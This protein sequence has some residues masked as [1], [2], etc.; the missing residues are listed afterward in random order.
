TPVSADV[1]AVAPGDNVVPAGHSAPRVDAVS[2]R[3]GA[4]PE[5]VAPNNDVAPADEIASSKGAG[6][7]PASAA[8]SPSQ[9]A[10]ELATAPASASAGASGGASASASAGA[11]ADASTGAPAT[12]GAL[13][14]TEVPPWEDVPMDDGDFILDTADVDDEFETLGADPAAEAALAQLA[15]RS[16]NG[17]G[18]KLA[19]ITAADW[20]TLVQ[21]LPLTGAAEQLARQTEWLGV[22]G[23]RVRLRVGIQTLAEISARSRFCTVLSEHFGTVI[24]VDFEVG[25]TGEGTAHAIEQAHLEKLQEQAEQAVQNDPLINALIREFDGQVV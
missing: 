20:P 24:D 19:N 13:P 17:Q 8:A 18:P 1:D 16:S 14:A 10:S 7:V 6:P 22:D 21:Q 25:E 15:P 12:N 23:N 3:D 2:T 9:S 5:D 4:S 11:S